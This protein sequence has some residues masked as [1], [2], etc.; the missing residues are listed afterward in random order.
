MFRTEASL[1]PPLN[2]L[3]YRQLHDRL[4][5]P[6][7]GVPPAAASV[8][9]VR[10]EPASISLPIKVYKRAANAPGITA[11]KTSIRDLHVFRWTYFLPE[12]HNSFSK[13]RMS[14]PVGG[15]VIGINTIQKEEGP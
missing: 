6:E 7:N 11:G 1:V 10:Q 4:A 14:V 13:K 3:L 12:A 5:V 15:S 8:R 2:A 9:P